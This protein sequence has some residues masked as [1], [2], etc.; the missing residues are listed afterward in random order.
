MSRLGTGTITEPNIR[1]ASLY[2]HCSLLPVVPDVVR[3]QDVK[4]RLFYWKHC[5]FLVLQ[6]HK[7]LVSIRI[8][9][10]RLME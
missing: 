6:M 7:P 4:Y 9:V 5:C 10:G 8:R 3:V 1:K 2:L